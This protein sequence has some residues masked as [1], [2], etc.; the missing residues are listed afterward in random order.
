MQRAA[1]LLG[2]TAVLMLAGC[3]SDSGNAS[4]D[5]M[6]MDETTGSPGAGSTT[7]ATTPGARTFSKDTARQSGEGSR[8]SDLVLV[9]VRVATAEGFARIVLEF[10]GTG[11]PGWVVNYV[12][13]RVIEGS[14]QAVDLGGR[15]ASDI[16]ASDTTWPARDYYDGPAR[17]VPRDSGSVTDVYVGGTFEGATQVLAGVDGAV[18][19]RVSMLT[20]PS[21]LVVDVVDVA[22][23]G[24]D[25][26]RPSRSHDA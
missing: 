14:G 26:A 3:V 10:S 6:A 17:V 21:R 16:Y 23:A 4:T 20:E 7:E 2:T 24:S 12:D 18:P 19:F 11:T 15:A 22:C 1:A 25:R 13:E 9:D 8:P 5:V